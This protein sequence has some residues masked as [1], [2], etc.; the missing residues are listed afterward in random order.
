MP[1]IA[2]VVGLTGPLCAGKT[3]V[4]EYLRVAHGVEVIS[5]REIVRQ[6][7]STTESTETVTRPELQD[8]GQWLQDNRGPLFVTERILERIV[9][10]RPFVIDAIRHVVSQ[11]K[12]AQVLGPRF[13]PLHITAPESLRRIRF[14]KREGASGKSF[15]QSN[16]HQIESDTEPLGSMS[17]AVID[18][19]QSLLEL[20]TQIGSLFQCW[21]Y[22]RIPISLQSA[23]EMVRDFHEKHGFDIGTCN[24][25]VLGQRLVLM[26]E[27]L[28]EVA[29]WVTRRQG[30][31]AEEHADLLI[32]LL[33]NA[34][35]MDLDL[36]EA[37]VR[38]A[39]KIFARPSKLIDGQKRVSHWRRG[40][41][42]ELSRLDRVRFETG[43]RKVT[44]EQ[45]VPQLNLNLDAHTEDGGADK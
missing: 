43:D 14:L 2:I 34:I 28:G 45:P 7:T 11:E 3:T 15:D 6:E 24:P 5:T 17:K 30:D 25:E 23:L 44:K 20:A 38:K 22:G 36:E 4:A 8:R 41:E 12:L 26:M 29:R 1:P 33:G 32:L 19:R 27:E 31:V 13:V 42:L 40:E 21:R 16:M 35:T 37:L 39:R 18:N 10:V 9:P